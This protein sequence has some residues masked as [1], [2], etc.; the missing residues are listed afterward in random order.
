MPEE[1]QILYSQTWEDPRVDQVALAPRRGDSVLGITAAGCTGL[2]LATVPLE[3]LVLVDP[4]PAQRYLVALE[5]VAMRHLALEEFRAFLGIDEAGD[6]LERYRQLRGELPED[7]RAFFD[8]REA[9]VAEG[10]VHVGIADR[11][12]RGLA[13]QLAGFVYGEEAVEALLACPDVASQARLAEDRCT[14]WWVRLKLFL[15]CMQGL[16]RPGFSRSTPARMWACAP[17]PRRALALARWAER[18]VREVPVRD[19]YFLSWALRGRLLEGPD[20]VPPHLTPEGYRAARDNLDR[21]RLVTGSLLETLRGCEDDSFDVFQLS[22][23]FEWLP[24]A[25]AAGV[26]EQVARTG[27]PWARLCYREQF[28]PCP[29]P[30]AL[31]ETLQLDHQLSAVLS[32]RER[33]GLYARVQVATVQKAASGRMGAA[34]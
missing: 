24:P 6:R 33:V 14:S 31:R 7:A 15:V 25:E 5:L 32:A 12:I 20:G 4:N 21:I 17:G 10:L 27:R 26:L 28:T 23:L 8:A 22:N 16:A 11:R 29:V 3:R 19:N 30:E 2:S 18:L 9:L 1:P 34:G 13:R